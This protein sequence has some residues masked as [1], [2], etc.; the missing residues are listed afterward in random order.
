[1]I[2]STLFFNYS[3]SK[4][5][6]SP[7]CKLITLTEVDGTSTST[8]NITYNSDNKVA[9]ITSTMVNGGT[10]SSSN[11]VCTYAGNVIMKTATSTSG[12]S[13]TTTT[14][15]IGLNSAGYVIA[16]MT[17]YSNS[18]DYYY[19]TFTYD[20]N[21]QLLK[22]T[23]QSNGGPVT[24]SIASYSNGDITYLASPG[25]T[26]Y[27]YYNTSRPSGNDDYL[28]LAEKVQYGGALVYKTAHQ[29]QALKYSGG[30]AIVNLD[31]TYDSKGNLATMIYTQGSDI[32]NYSFQY[33]CGN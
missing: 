8:D 16:D 14:D 20:A 32:Q 5:S 2:A 6:S 25:D 19:T 15:S 22:S 4:K 31:Y 10:T 33:D 26:T 24:T 28:Y 30:S 11:T 9:T 17:R 12:S 21:N 18:S 23:S 7:P 1:M 13:T 27:L 29:L 3:C